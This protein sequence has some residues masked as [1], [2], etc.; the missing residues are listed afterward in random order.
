M[1]LAHKV[2]LRPSKQQEQYLLQLCGASRHLWNKL[3]HHF[4]GDGVKW[5]KN[6]LEEGLRLANK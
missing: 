5:S 4:S 1:L 2:E 3:L 6:I